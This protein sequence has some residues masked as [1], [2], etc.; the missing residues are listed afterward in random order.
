[1]N[2]ALDLGVLALALFAIIH[3]LCDLVWLEVLSFTSFKGTHLFG[4]R[5]QKIV[6]AVCSLSMLVIGAA[7][8]ID[9]GRKLAR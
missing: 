1:M 6:L 9:A 4:H 7:F 8:I 3:W 2:R 5:T